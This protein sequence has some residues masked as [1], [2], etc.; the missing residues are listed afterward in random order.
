M[1]Y[2]WSL[3][4]A[5]WERCR[6][7]DVQWKKTTLN[8]LKQDSVPLGPGVYAI[9]A[10]PAVLGSG[11][12]EKLYNVVYVGRAQGGGGLRTRFLAHC[13]RPSPQLQLA[14]LCF[15]AELDYWFLELNTADVAS[16]ESM[17]IDCLG[18]IVNLVGGVIEARIGEPT[19]A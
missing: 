19:S 7:A 6:I 2:G 18:P 14:K 3:D 1:R 13:H 12:L 9:C 5:A 15:G 4:H 10:R 8:P 17:L 16:T 11:V